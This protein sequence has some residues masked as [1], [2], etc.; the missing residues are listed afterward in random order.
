MMF[1]ENIKEMNV[2]ATGN[3]GVKE[4]MTYEDYKNDSERYFVVLSLPLVSYLKMRKFEY[5]VHLNS[6]TN[7]VY[8]V[9]NRSEALK[10]AVMDWNIGL[11]KVFANTLSE[12]KQESLSVRELENIKK[13]QGIM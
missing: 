4:V 12:T 6:K 8:Y 13:A 7:S 2:D 1:K 10:D 5:E 9:F 3:T 11:F